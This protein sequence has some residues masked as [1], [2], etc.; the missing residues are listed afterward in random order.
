MREIVIKQYKNNFLFLISFIRDNTHMKLRKA[1]L[2]R[3]SP[4]NNN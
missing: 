1:I 3:I 4:Q 2:V